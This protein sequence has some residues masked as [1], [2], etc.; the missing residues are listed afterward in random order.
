MTSNSSYAKRD[1]LEIAIPDA[2]ERKVSFC[3]RY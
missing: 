3:L 1:A 2:A